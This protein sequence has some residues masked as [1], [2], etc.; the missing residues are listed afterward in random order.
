MTKREQQH[1][2]AGVQLERERADKLS[3]FKKQ[4]G[5][6]IGRL[7]NLAVDFFIPAFE[8][9]EVEIV[10]GKIVPRQKAA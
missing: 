3:K 4:T 10:N 5:L 7:A 9:G 1:K 8:R 2:G 6:S